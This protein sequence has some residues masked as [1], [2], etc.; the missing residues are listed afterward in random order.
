MVANGWVIRDDDWCE[1]G[2]HCSWGAGLVTRHHFDE[3]SG[4]D[5][6]GMTTFGSSSWIRFEDEVSSDGM[7][8]E[9]ELVAESMASTS[10]RALLMRSPASSS[11]LTRCRPG[12]ALLLQNQTKKLKKKCKKRGEEGRSYP[13]DRLGWCCHHIVLAWLPT[14]VTLICERRAGC[15]SL[16]LPWEEH[17][18]H[19]SALAE[20]CPIPNWNPR[21]GPKRQKKGFLG[22]NQRM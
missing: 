10:W 6:R 7:E 3:D 13:E 16:F 12:L 14:P 9:S 19:D 18:Y 1:L 21:A 20:V 4:V 2:V 8:L 11:A 5:H 22:M 15:R 17:P